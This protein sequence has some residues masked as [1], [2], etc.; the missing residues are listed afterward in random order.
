MVFS[1]MHAERNLFTRER[2][3]G[4]YYPFT[5]LLAKVSRVVNYL[6]MHAY[7]DGSFPLSDTPLHPPRESSAR[8]RGS[9]PGEPSPRH[10]A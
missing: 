3:D 8:T 4:L 2:H 7:G 1:R 9:G 6:C 10:T 5:D